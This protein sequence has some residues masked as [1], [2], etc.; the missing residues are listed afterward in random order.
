MTGLIDCN[1]FFVSCERVRDPSLEGLPV[2]V[3]S[4]NGGCVVAL[5]DEAKAL[6]IKRT[7]PY[8][9]IRAFCEANGVVALSGSLRLYRT[10]SDRVM[11]VI[12]EHAG[13]SLEIYSIDE[14][15]ISIEPSLGDLADYGHY[16]VDTIR[17]RTGIPVSLGIAS[18]KTM[19]KL[20]A[21]FAKKFKGYNGVCVIDTDEKRLKALSMT[22]VGDVWGIGPRLS[23]K[24][25]DVGIATALD[26]YNLPKDR[27]HRFLHKNAA[28][29]WHEL[30]GTACIK[31]HTPQAEHRSISVSRTLP[32]D[33]SDLNELTRLIN[34]YASSAAR[35]LRR[36]G[37]LTR[38]I[39]VILRT[40][41]FRQYASQYNPTATIRLP[42]HTD[43]TPDICSA[44]AEALNSIYREGVLFKRAGVTLH[45]LTDK[46]PYQQNIFA[47]IRKE[48][49]KRRL[50]DLMDRINDSD[51]RHS[52]TLRIASTT[53]RPADK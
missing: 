30:H 48:E 6:G 53:N 45:H 47:D 19:A 1:N 21:R 41:R 7:E 49:K 34:T 10:I 4:N 33:T 18:T 40:N 17:H 31:H 35:E 24:L 16:L 42:D 26:L 15:F 36:K 43:Y 11:S 51:D 29:T 44:A 8:F 20:A 2:I 25:A 32:H 13:D 39:T 50:M 46:K 12:R 3:L 37:F 22:A 14:A 5:S 28:D 52:P 27:I 38:E 23:R 9:K